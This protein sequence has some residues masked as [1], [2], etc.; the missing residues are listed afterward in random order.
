MSDLDFNSASDMSEADGV[1]LDIDRGYLSFGDRLDGN[2]SESATTNSQTEDEDGSG[3]IPQYSPPARSQM[4]SPHSNLNL[5]LRNLREG[6]DS[7][8]QHPPNLVEQADPASAIVPADP[9]NPMQNLQNFQAIS[10]ERIP[11]AKSQAGSDFNF[12]LSKE[13]KAA[14]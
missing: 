6:R 8:G 10:N 2:F 7:D 5:N 1:H 3:T 12:D 9:A 13:E 4:S 14:K 11:A